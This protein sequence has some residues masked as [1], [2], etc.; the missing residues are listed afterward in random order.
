MLG[1][2][3]CTIKM[4]QGGMK[5]LIY[6]EDLAGIK[7]TVINEPVP[8]IETV[9]VTTDGNQLHAKCKSFMEQYLPGPIIF[10]LFFEEDIFHGTVLMLGTEIPLQGTRGRGE[11][12]QEKLIQEVRSYRKENVI[13]RSDAEIKSAVG[14]L[15]HKMSIEEKIGQM[16]QCVSSEFAFGGAVESDPPEKLIA[17]GKVGTI[18]GAY[19]ISRSFELQRIAVEQSPH[20]IPLFVNSDI[21]HGFQTIFPVPLAWSCSWDLDAIKKACAI[22]A[23]EATVSGITYNNSPMVDVTRDARWGRVMEGAGEDPYLGSQ[24]AKA[25]VEGFQGDSLFHEETLLACLKHFVAYGAAEAGRDYNTVD[26]SEGTLRN[27]YL[28]PFEAGIKAG[29]GS[30]MN[31]FNIYDGIP[32]AGNQYLLK[33]VLREELGFDG[34]ILSDYGAV[35][36]IRI[37][38][39]A[40]DNAVAAKLALDAT[41]DIEMVTRVYADEL[42][43]LLKQGIICEE[44][45]DSAVSR[46]L[47]YKYKI[48]IMDDPFR[49]IRPEKET[50]YHFSA[51]HLRHSRDLARKS[52]VLLKNNHVLPLQK[53]K[54][55]ALIGPFATSKDLLGAW[56]FTKYANDTVTIYQGFREKGIG[57]EQIQ[58][59]LG[60]NVDSS[61]EGGVEQAILAAKAADVVVLALG[62]SSQMSGE[63]ASR[64]DINLPK[65][66]L[67]LAEEIVKLGK[68]TVLIL[69]NGRPLELEWFDKNVDGIVETWYLGSQA[70]HAIA[71]VLMGDYNP[72]GRLTMSFP[73][74]VGQ[75]PIYYNH[76]STGRPQTSNSQSSEYLTRYIDVPNEPLYPFGFGLSYATFEYSD[77]ILS[78]KVL[79]RNEE[80]NVS[81]TVKNTG[82]Y[83]GEETVQLYIQDLYGSTVRPVKELKRFQKIYLKPGESQKIKFVLSEED[84]KFYT[85]KRRYEAEAGEFKVFVGGNSK[86]TMD[87][88]FVLI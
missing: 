24:I 68:P 73:Y 44:Q 46:I 82:A 83:G 16:C 80:L 19:D 76:F 49:Y 86:D 47:T 32:M 34:I 78:K 65:V 15:L 29:A 61:I 60:C 10:D 59:E 88:S 26:I 12:N 25:Q 2:W 35:E 9:S 64:A 7:F 74:H 23:K 66:Q 31:A 69:T 38:G 21:I 87:I 81:V 84:L 45:I 6:V 39:C 51:E 67:Q 17:E 13:Q 4:N 8:I 52:I 77:L 42:P 55:I 70:G 27:V 37:H 11:A 43:E 62:E 79:N 41:L 22:A 72:T 53:D 85:A 20:K 5:V 1:V 18:L 33:D 58:C 71:D 48:G 14:E 57:K 54:K 28:K 3:N 75:E 50:E 56:Q 30:V 40:K 63:N 36:E